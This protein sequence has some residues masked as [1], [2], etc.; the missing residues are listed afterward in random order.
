MFFLHPH[1]SYLADSLPD[2]QVVRFEKFSDGWPRIFLE[3]KS[4]L[5]GKEITYIGDFRNVEDFF[6]QIAF[7]DGLSRHHIDT[8]HIVIPFFPAA[9]M[10]RDTPNGELSIANVFARTFGLI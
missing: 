5:V 3:Y 4:A 9:S 10:E 6:S 8:L 7:L 1:F 2:A